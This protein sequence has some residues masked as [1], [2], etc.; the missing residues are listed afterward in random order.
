M[1]KL[2]MLA[3]CLAYAA[4]G[5]PAST[6]SPSPPLET[7]PAPFVLPFP[8]G[9]SYVCQMTFNDPGSHFGL[10]R[11]SVDFSMPIGTIVTA[12]QAGR[13]VYVLQRYDDNDR[14][15]GHENVVIVLHEDSTYS[16]YAHL[17]RNGARVET[18]RELSAGDTIGL[19]GNSGSTA[20]PHL[21]FDVVRNADQR[22]VPTIPFAFRNVSPPAAILQAGVRYTALAY[23]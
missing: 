23:H 12:A 8:V 2:L 6:P 13:V 14:T 19:S 20:A 17:T 5:N 18:G 11:Y 15:S 10:F 22:D 16:R 4:C 9:E 7:E 3:C 21:H 1:K